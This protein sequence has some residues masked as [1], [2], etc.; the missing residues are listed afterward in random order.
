MISKGIPSR[1]IQ[2]YESTKNCIGWVL[3]KMALKDY[4]RLSMLLGADRFK[5]SKA[6]LV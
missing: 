4:R 5:L 1:K 3:A 6:L 2:N